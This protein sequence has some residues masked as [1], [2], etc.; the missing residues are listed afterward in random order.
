MR[1]LHGFELGQS[2]PSLRSETVRQAA[3]SRGGRSI[4]SFSPLPEGDN[5]MRRIAFDGVFF[6]VSP[7]FIVMTFDPR[8]TFRLCPSTA[9]LP[10][11]SSSSNIPSTWF[12]SP[13]SVDIGGISRQPMALPNSA[14]RSPRGISLLPAAPSP[15]SQ[16][17]RGTSS[18][19]PLD[20]A[21]P[22]RVLVSPQPPSSA[23]APHLWLHTAYASR[24]S[25]RPP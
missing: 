16:P 7:E 6:R 11:S 2:G 25:S 17:L 12:F 20:R 22:V 13:M 1:M 9:Q 8:A 3:L 10:P 21:A 14:C 15:T 5:D 18:T 23:P 19:S 24:M 4:S